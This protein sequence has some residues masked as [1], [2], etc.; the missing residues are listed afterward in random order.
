MTHRMILAT[1]DLKV[2][3]KVVEAKKI[4]GIAQAAEHSPRKREDEFSSNST[5]SRGE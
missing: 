2:V 5:S 4:A 1:A 3:H